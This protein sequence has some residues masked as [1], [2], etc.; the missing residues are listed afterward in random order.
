VFWG[1]GRCYKICH[2]PAFCRG[3]P[4]LSS[5]RVLCGLHGFCPFL[6]VL[7]AAGTE[8]ILDLSVTKCC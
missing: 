8:R 3:D 5:A 4:S 7:L 1:G 6:D 2:K